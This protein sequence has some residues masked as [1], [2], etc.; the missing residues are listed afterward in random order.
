MSLARSGLSLLFGLA[1]LAAATAAA[2]DPPSPAHDG[3]PGL[4]G[5]SAP[6]PPGLDGG[7]AP[8]PPGLDGGSAPKPRGLD[9]GSAPR[10]PGLD[11]G[12]APRP[13]DAHGPA[14]TGR[15]QRA[16]QAMALH[17]EAWRLYEEGRYRA[18]IDRLEAALLLD[19][20]GREL[21][22]NLALIHEKLADI[23]DAAGYYQR[24]L[25]MEPDPKTRAR[26]QLVLRR[27]EGAEK[28]AATP[29]RD[30]G[31]RAAPL[32]PPPGPP[33]PRPVRPWVVTTASVGGVAFVMGSVFGL[34]ALA[35]NPGANAHTGGSVT[36]A[37]LQADAHAAHVDAVISDVSFLATLAAAGTAAFLYLAT[38]RTAGSL[39]G[40]RAVA[41][42]PSRLRVSF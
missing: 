32:A 25:D 36:I 31:P 6:K 12:S 27:L 20:E 1:A 9:G 5:G 13:P 41:L 33:P 30:V 42:A 28:E 23:R 21:V 7:S 10:P 40:A 24:Y 22:Y 11:G 37:D 3:P 38:P 17:D 39:T 14:P 4:D 34:A 16:H 19:P 18:A 26:I 35:R 29:P 8:R 2:A 15:D